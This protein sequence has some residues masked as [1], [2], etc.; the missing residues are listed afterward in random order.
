MERPLLGTEGL[1]QEF[2][3]AL[4]SSNA[5]ATDPQGDAGPPGPKISIDRLYNEIDGDQS[6]RSDR[7]YRQY[8]QRLFRHVQPYEAL[9]FIPISVAEMVLMK[10]SRLNNNVNVIHVWT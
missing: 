10:Y 1:R 3:H 4:F 8:L 9:V 5:S 2:G 7:R 6:I